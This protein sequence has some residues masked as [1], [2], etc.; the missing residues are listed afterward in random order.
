[1]SKNRTRIAFNIG[2]IISLLYLPWWIGALI[3]LAGA[4]L[5]E[6]FYEVVVYGILFDVLYGTVTGFH[7]VEYTGTFFT[8]VVFIL[9]LVIRG[10][11]A[12]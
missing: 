9:A 8:I 3:A 5:V 10:R 1:M 7:G 4:F 11:L 6:G 2:L 12:W